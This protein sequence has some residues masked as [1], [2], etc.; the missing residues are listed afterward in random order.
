MTAMSWQAVK[1]TRRDWLRSAAA[2]TAGLAAATTRGFGAAVE[3]EAFVPIRAITSGPRFHWFGYYDKLEF[4]PSNRYV[5]SNEVEFEHR[6]PTAADRIQ[7][8]MVD[9][10]DGDKWIPL[11]KSDAWGWQQGCM[12]Q[13]RP[14]T[15]SEVL[16]NDREDGRFVCHILDVKTGAKRTLPRP[17]YSV[18]PDGKWAVT[19]DFARIQAMRPGY[20]Y[21]GIPDPC[22]DQKSPQDSGIWRVNLETGDS[23][24]IVSLDDVVK[25]LHQGEDL[26]PHWNYFN[27]LLIN[28]DGTRF[29]FLHRG[30]RSGRGTSRESV[31]GC[32][33]DTYR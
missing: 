22:A 21:Q 17:V 11:G 2:A 6:T 4:D 23:Q 12:L 16:W 32:G 15:A 29:I 8:G 31:G 3:S 26:R 25:I 27:H 1:C 13:W 14:G 10:Q 33:P 9:T 24:L 28:P 20:G 18:S 30:G 5:L 19:A 7:V